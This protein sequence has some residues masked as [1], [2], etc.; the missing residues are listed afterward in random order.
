MVELLAS[1]DFPDPPAPPGF[2]VSIES[3]LANYCRVALQLES[4]EVNPC[5]C[6][7]NACGKLLGE[8][9]IG[10][11]DILLIDK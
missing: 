5:K 6:S 3:Y 9:E 8:M 10:V 4:W 7:A 11:F 1:S 2:F